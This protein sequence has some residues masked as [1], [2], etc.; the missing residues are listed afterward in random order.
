M[1]L[2]RDRGESSPKPAESPQT[3]S[4]FLLP[5]P[6]CKI[7]TQQE[8]IWTLELGEIRKTADLVNLCPD[9][10]WGDA[11]KLRDWEAPISVAFTQKLDLNISLL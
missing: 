2:T 10:L 7:T 5:L 9:T 3:E 1:A 4:A 8:S 11:L 6:P